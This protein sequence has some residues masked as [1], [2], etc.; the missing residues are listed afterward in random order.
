MKK[1]NRVLIVLSSILLTSCNISINNSSSSSSNNSNEVSSS[2]SSS[3]ESSSNLESSSSKQDSSVSFSSTSS[4]T[5]SS[6][7]Q[8][9]SSSSSLSSVS[10][11]SD[12]KVNVLANSCN[13]LALEIDKGTISSLSYKL[14]SESN[15][16]ELDSNCI[17]ENKATILGLK[18]G[19]YDIKIKTLDNKQVSLNDIEVE[20][21]D[22]SGY[23]TF[24]K[25]SIGAYNV[26]GSLLSNAQVIYVDDSNKNTVAL[27]VGSSTYIGLGNIFKNISKVSFPLDIRIVGAI[28][29][30]QFKSKE[31][32]PLTD[33]ENPSSSEFEDRFKN[34]LETTYTNLDGL[35]NKIFG[36]SSI[37]YN[38]G[39][40]MTFS[41]KTKGSDTDS[42]FNMMQVKNASN[43][44][45]EGIFNGTINQWGFNFKECNSI[46]VRNLTFKDYPEDACSFEGNSKDITSSS[47]FF[48]HNNTFLIGKN[49]WD[50]TQEQ[51]KH[52]GDGSSDIKYLS[53]YTSSYNHFI[54][55]HKTGLVGG[56][57]TQM[58][59]NVTFHHN[60]YES[61]SSR[62]PLGRQ[63]NMHIYNCY[64]KE[65]G[66][67]Q[68]IRANAFVLSEANYFENTKNPQKVTIVEK[69]DYYPNIKSFNDILTGCGTSQAKLVT[70]REEKVTNKCKPN[71]IDLSSFDTDSNLF[72]Y[73][74]TNK[75]SKVELLH[76]AKDVPN[77]VSKY[78][79]NLYL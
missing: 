5:T 20:K 38:Y 19:S 33:S 6:S 60:Y 77:F 66:T 4:Q 68:D 15:Y 45:I 21:Q 72:Y 44:T 47:N 64:Y 1:V 11:S 57:D 14:V 50:L 52:E 56:G 48:L 43:I 34:T 3:S 31:F 55:C 54:K 53:N 26:D 76:E 61:V 37:S 2:Q 67:G 17:S 27:K 42:A 32:T 23:A 25:T 29:T 73:D 8:D 51:D 78:S 28:N 39:V 12:I 24:N 36:P 30:N 70:S 65:C 49:N 58:T 79:G 9:T 63:A 69:S 75:V 71:G 46:E 22:M 40:D 35:T 41:S 16:I 13:R 18:K 59:Q 74:S 62:L 10:E 7:S